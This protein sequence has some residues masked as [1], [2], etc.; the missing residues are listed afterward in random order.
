MLLTGSV[1]FLLGC[2]WGYVVARVAGQRQRIEDCENC[3][4]FR[5]IKEQE[6]DLGFVSVEK[7]G[8]RV[9]LFN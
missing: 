6:H 3:Q 2:L 1:L 5:N 7:R 4:W 8:S 9:Q